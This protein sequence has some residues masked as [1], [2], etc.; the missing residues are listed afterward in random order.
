MNSDQFP[1]MCLI[2][3]IIIII[4]ITIIIIIIIIIYNAL[5][6]FTIYFLIFTVS[7]R[8]L[9]RLRLGLNYLNIHRYHKLKNCVDPNNIVV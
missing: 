7:K 2:F 1:I 5:Q 9:T 4:I 8:L 6:Y 3:T